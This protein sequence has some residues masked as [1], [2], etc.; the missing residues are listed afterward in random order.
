M[1]EQSDAWW[2]DD[3]TRLFL[4]KCMQ[5]EGTA[6]LT[7]DKANP[8]RFTCR[9]VHSVMMQGPC[10]A[11]FASCCQL[12]SVQHAACNV[13]YMT[14]EPMS[15]VTPSQLAEMAPERVG[16]LWRKYMSAFAGKHIL[17]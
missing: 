2:M 17:R 7:I 16:E 12:P 11:C 8:Q 15:C 9:Q 14:V 4:F 10:R 13:T 6:V 1:R 3:A 5:L